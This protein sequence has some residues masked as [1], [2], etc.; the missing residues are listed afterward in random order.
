MAATAVIKA[1]SLTPIDEN[2][3]YRITYGG[4]T[5]NSAS[6]VNSGVLALVDG[7]LKITLPTSWAFGSGLHVITWEE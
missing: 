5:A 2:N 1:L 4:T 6:K 7:K 3:M